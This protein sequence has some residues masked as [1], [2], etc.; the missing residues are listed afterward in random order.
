M[1]LIPYTDIPIFYLDSVVVIDKAM[2]GRMLQRDRCIKTN[3][4]FIGC[5]GDALEVTDRACSG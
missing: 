4:G 2:Y 1:M 3:Y 5:Y